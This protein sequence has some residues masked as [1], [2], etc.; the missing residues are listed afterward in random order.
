MSD[1]PNLFAFG[2]LKRKA[3]ATGAQRAAAAEARE[4]Q[5]KQ[6]REQ[7]AAAAL[8]AKLAGDTPK[9]TGL[10]RN[11]AAVAK[12]RLRAKQRAPT[13]KKSQGPHGQPHGRDKAAV[14]AEKASAQTPRKVS[15][16][17][18]EFENETHY[19]DLA[20]IRRMHGAASGSAR[21]R[22]CGQ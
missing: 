7:I 21:S 16:P 13:K 11:P 8:A 12:R 15:A 10:S 19:V 22:C 1:P 3:E 18:S 6:Q 9:A 14:D 4:A 5:E 20:R 17:A 2:W